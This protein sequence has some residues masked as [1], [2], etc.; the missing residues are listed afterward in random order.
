MSIQTIASESIVQQLLFNFL[1]GFPM[2]I[3]YESKGTYI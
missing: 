1:S 2:H 3:H